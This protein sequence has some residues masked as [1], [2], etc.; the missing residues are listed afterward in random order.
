MINHKFWFISKWG[1]KKG[2]ES[3]IS[4]SSCFFNLSGLIEIGGLLL[5]GFFNVLFPSRL[6]TSDDRVQYQFC[7]LSSSVPCSSPCRGNTEEYTNNFTHFPLTSTSSCSWTVPA[8]PPPNL[9]WVRFS[10]RPGP[11]Y[12]SCHCHP[13]A[14]LHPPRPWSSFAVQFWSLEMWIKGHEDSWLLSGLD[15]AI[16]FWWRTHQGCSCLVPAGLLMPFPASLSWVPEVSGIA[17]N[18]KLVL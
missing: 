15:W 10:K 5:R 13:S 6:D 1:E 3:Q 11:D 12:A 2:C 7:C 9:L 16:N 8:F 4:Y 14:G 18:E 17:R